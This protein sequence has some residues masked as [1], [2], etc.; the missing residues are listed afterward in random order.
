MRLFGVATSWV[1]KVEP[2]GRKDGQKKISCPPP[3]SS[4]FSCFGKLWSSSR[5]YHCRAVPN[6]ASQNEDLPW[7]ARL[8]DTARNCLR[9]CC[10]LGWP[11]WRVVR[12]SLCELFFKEAERASARPARRSCTPM[13]SGRRQKKHHQKNRSQEQS[14]ME[15]DIILK[16]LASEQAWQA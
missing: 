16:P 11:S 12:A 3:A 8:L 10:W 2:C 6:K 9:A 13:C 4:N 15:G 5:L 7:L 1:A 14:V